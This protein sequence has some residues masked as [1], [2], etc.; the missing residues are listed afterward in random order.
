MKA[1]VWGMFLVLV[2]CG[3]RPVAGRV[4]VDVKPRTRFLSFLVQNNTPD[5]ALSHV[6]AEAA[7]SELGRRN[8]L[9]ASKLGDEDTVSLEF[10]LRSTS[11]IP[12]SFSP[13]GSV[14]EYYGDVYF[15]Y[16]VYAS[17]ATVPIV[18]VNSERISYRFDYNANPQITRQIRFA[19][20]ANSIRDWVPLLLWQTANGMQYPS[21]VSPAVR[22]VPVVVPVLPPGNAPVPDTLERREP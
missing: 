17:D 10:I 5:L 20:I 15:D 7:R 21:T 6:V 12:A 18:V 13:V 1:F 19:A 11:E 14:I 2:S 3:Y 8:L 4:A 22:K 9:S 16:R